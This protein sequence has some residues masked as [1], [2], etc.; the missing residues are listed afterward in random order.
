MTRTDNESPIET[1]RGEC[2][3]TAQEEPK[4]AWVHWTACYDDSCTTHWSSKNDEGHGWNTIYDDLT[5]D[6]EV[7]ALRLP[8]PQQARDDGYYARGRPPP[9]L[10]RKDTTLH[11]NDKDSLQ[12][13]SDTESNEQ[14]IALQ[15]T[16]QPDYDQI[17]D[18]GV[19]PEVDG[20]T[21]DQ[22]PTPEESEDE[23]SDDDEPDDNEVLSFTADE[24]EPIRR[25]VLRLARRFEEMFPRISG[26]RRLHPHEFE[27]T[28]LQLRSMF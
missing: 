7:P 19:L 12:E 9:P 14:A 10:M 11:H 28:M 18:L 22:V 2:D 13:E 20:P 21:T 4:H 26:K 6:D 16:R 24:P 8:S 15:S 23:Y 3:T 25:M 27:Q 17:I 1:T 5:L